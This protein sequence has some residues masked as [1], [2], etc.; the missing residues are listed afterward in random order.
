M[1]KTVLLLESIHK[2]VVETCEEYGFQVTTF[3]G[4][5]Q[6]SELIS[7]C[8]TQ[9][10][11]ILGIRSKTHVSR[12]VLEACPS[13][14]I[15]G[16]FCIG[17]DTV[18]LDAARELG[19]VVFNSPFSSGRSVAELCLAEII[20]LSRQLSDKIIE[21]HRGVWLKSSTGSREVRGRTLGIV[22]YGNI[23]CQ[24]S[25]LA[26]AL[27]MKVIYFDILSKTSIGNAKAV[28]FETVLTESDFVTL[29]I[30]DTELTRGMIGKDQLSMMKKGSVLLNASR[31]R[32]VDLDALRVNLIEGHLSG[33]AID[34]HPDE[35]ISNTKDW[36]SPL[37]GL[38]NVILTPHIGG[39]TEEA[40][41]KIGLDVS[42]KIIRFVRDCEIVDSV[43]YTGITLNSSG[44]VFRICHIHQ[45]VPG[46]LKKLNTILDSVNIV[47][48]SLNTQGNVGIC[49]LDCD[50]VASDEQIEQI[51]NMAETIRVYCV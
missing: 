48:Q 47:G 31:G 43:N 32:V 4:S 38:S 26:E 42:S 19:V 45:N 14:M 7:T 17:T 21:L 16:C 46:V 1:F 25:I 40:Q 3:P 34:V 29:H 41:E 11:N 18:D 30:P 51:W 27:G 12:K 35:P 39:S 36:V 33:C 44:R 6:E 20:C 15:V 2:N 10:I 37:Q 22:G 50:Q 13:I 9:N 5:L 23:G 49:L 24:I 28:S 8:Q